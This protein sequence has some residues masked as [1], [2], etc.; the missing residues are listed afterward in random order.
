MNIL[1]INHYAGTPTLGMEYRPYYLAREWAKQGHSTTIIASSFSHVRTLQPKVDKQITYQNIDGINYVWIKTNSYNGNGIG[2]VLNIFSFVLKLVIFKK[3]ITKVFKPDVIIASSTYPLDIIPAKAIAKKFNVKLIFELHDLWPL[4]P[5]MLG[6]MSAYH[7]FIM[8]M[9][10]AENYTFKSCHKAISILPNTLEHMLAHGLTAEKF[11][12][13]P[14]GIVLDDWQH[15]NPL[16]EDIK[17][18]LIQLKQ[19]NKTLI[20]YVGTHGVANA[21]H[22]LIE[23]AQSDLNSNNIYILIGKGAEKNTLIHFCKANAITNVLFFDSIDKRSIPE[24]LSFFDILY[25]GLQNQPLFRFGISPNKLF[26]Y[27]MAGKPIVLSLESGSDIIKQANCGII[28]KAEN[29]IEISKAIQTLVQM[30][31][32]ERENL[33]RNGYTFVNKYHTFE[34]LANDFLQIIK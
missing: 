25:I 11:Y 7:P 16:D 32:E 24:L 15:P 26:D 33:G 22:S 30:T 1:I 13:V 14:N 31:K 19:T 20:G 9:Q 28:C 4:S 27:M 6:G 12:H 2:R 17:K 21:L 18:Q 23:A 5:M 34:N 3:S 8:L 10:W 29:S